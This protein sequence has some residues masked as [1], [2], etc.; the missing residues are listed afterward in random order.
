MFDAR[1]QPICVAVAN[2]SQWHR[3]CQAIEMPELADDVRFRCNADR[4]LNR[5]DLR[6]LLERVFRSRTAEEWVTALRAESVPCGPVNTV[7]EAFDDPHI[8]GRQLAAEVK[9][10][11][12]GRSVSLPAVVPA[13]LASAAVNSASPPLMGESTVDV[14]RSLRYTDDAIAALRRE[15]VIE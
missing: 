14:L 15:G 5:H 11:A 13:E 1:D 7:A 6:P 8:S 2:E 3:L 9:L 12:S 10:A 4:L